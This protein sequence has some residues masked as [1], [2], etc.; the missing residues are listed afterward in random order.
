MNTEFVKVECDDGLILHGLLF[1]PDKSTNKV[2]LHIHGMCGNFY[3]NHFVH[4]IM[5]KCIENG[6]AFLTVG[7]RGSEIMRYFEKK[8][9]DKSKDVRIG[10]AF[11][12]FEESQYDIKG[13]VSFLEKR[14]YKNVHLQSHSLGPTK[15]VYYRNLH[16][17]NIKSLIFLAP[18]DMIGLIKN[19]K[20]FPIH[21]ELLKEAKKLV[22]EGKEEAMLSKHLWDFYWLSAKTY[23]NFFD[24]GNNLSIFNFYNPELGFEKISNIDI[25][26]LSIIGTADSAIVTDHE[27]SM[28]MIG[29][30][31][32]KCPK[33]DYLV[34][35]GSDHSFRGF[36]DDVAD[37]VMEFV[38]GL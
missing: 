27:K 25:P 34:I 35:E 12:M 11:E 31:A 14:G 33:S 32:T 29:E 15:V 17:Q 2:I 28:K 8:E 5:K 10:N 3:E 13:W 19:P 9:G 24:E 23:V 37:K 26:I 6:F 1:N 38:K 16:K 20:D 30:K 7:Q 4:V 36:E 22:L 18:A 21:K